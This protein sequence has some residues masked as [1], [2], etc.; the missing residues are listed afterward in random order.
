MRGGSQSG[1]EAGG[2]SS[3][4]DEQ[5]PTLVQTHGVHDHLVEKETPKK[6]RE[7][8]KKK[9]KKKENKASEGFGCLVD[10]DELVLDRALGKRQ[11]R[12]GRSRSREGGRQENVLVCGGIGRNSDIVGSEGR[13]RSR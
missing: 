3:R 1:A 6:D 10:G 13:E 7:L 12:G 8:K 11:G 5:K 4:N 9:K 2:L